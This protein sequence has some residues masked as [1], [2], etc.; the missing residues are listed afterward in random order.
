MSDTATRAAA[1]QQQQAAGVP[2]RPPPRIISAPSPNHGGRRSRT[3]GCV[4][5]STRG[6]APTYQQEFWGTLNWFAAS[7]SRVSAHVVIAGDGTLAEVVDP[8]LIAWHAR[9]KNVTHLGVELVQPR[10]GDPITDAQYSTLAWWLIQMSRKYGFPLD[11]EHLPEHRETPEG[12][13]IGKTDIGPPFDRGRLL[14]FVSRIGGG[15]TPPPGQEGQRMMS[16]QVLRD[17]WTAVRADIPFSLRLGLCAAWAERPIEYGSP[18]GPERYEP[19]GSVYQAFTRAV[20]RWRPGV[21][22]ERV[23]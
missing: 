20:L 16:E 22:V 11:H 7:K 1:I 9:A 8:D 3:V 6:G 2:L 13:A 15:A 4:L 23:A 10:L 17:L 5:H 21:G 12:I 14:W 19:D 18:V